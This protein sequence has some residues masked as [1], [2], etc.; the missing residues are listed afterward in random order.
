MNEALLLDLIHA[1]TSDQ[2][3]KEALD[4]HAKRY[5]KEGGTD[6]LLSDV[7]VFIC[8]R[9]LSRD[10][11]FH[12]S[13]SALNSLMATAGWGFGDAPLGFWEV[14]IAFDDFDTSD[15][16]NEEARPRIEQELRRLTDEFFFPP[17][18]L[19]PDRRDLDE[20]GAAGTRST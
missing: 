5:S 20:I 12:D 4:T 2:L 19:D 16:P 3:T 13:G 8:T 18:I 15:D 14:F 11:S 10:S 17:G 6:R 7:A 1:A 9:F